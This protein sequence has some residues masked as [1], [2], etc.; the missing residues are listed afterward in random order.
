MIFK[1]MQTIFLI[2]VEAPAAPGSLHAA[3][4]ATINE[5]SMLNTEYP[6]IEPVIMSYLIPILAET[7][8]PLG[9]TRTSDLEI[10]RITFYK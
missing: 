8:S 4:E 5:K 10:K 9:K 6:T 3:K 1:V 7:S 2:T